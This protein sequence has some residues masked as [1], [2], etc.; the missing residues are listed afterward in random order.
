MQPLAA[1]QL[2]TTQAIVVNGATSDEINAV[3]ALAQAALSMAEAANGRIDHL[4][5]INDPLETLDKATEL[6]EVRTTRNL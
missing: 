1:P 6:S 2:G 3:L 5:V 4:V